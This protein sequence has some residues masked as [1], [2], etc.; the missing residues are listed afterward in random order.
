MHGRAHAHISGNGSRKRGRAAFELGFT[1]LEL[2]IAIM[3]LVIIIVLMMGA[4]RMGARSVVAGE[5][6]MDM[7][8]RYRTVLSIVDAQIQSQSPLTFQE[9]GGNKKYYFRGDR[10]NLRFA[11]NY[12]IW[13]G[14]RGYVIAE[15]WV[16]ADNSGQEILYA[17]EQSPGGSGRR[18]TRFLAA[19]QISF[20]Y[21]QKNPAE[22]QGKWVESLTDGNVV[23]EKIRLNLLQEKRTL[24]V[25]FPVRVG[26]LTMA[27]QGGTPAAANQPG[28]GPTPG[29]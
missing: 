15:Y 8:E 1:L 21:F 22:E 2:L 18:N 6:R 4:M 28:R 3:L 14:Q 11:T 16:E 9:E 13:G 5:R 17:A 25:M 27:L 20:E 7:Q 19:N 29:K 12:S 26:G 10:K 23:P 24:S